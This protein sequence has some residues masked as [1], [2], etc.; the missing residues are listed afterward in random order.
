MFLGHFWLFLH[1]KLA[2]F[3]DFLSEKNGLPWIVCAQL[4]QGSRVYILILK[5]L[6]QD[7][8]N[9]TVDEM[10]QY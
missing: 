2:N 1:S 6:L 8:T 7:A 4:I 3:R 10:P 9:F 5:S